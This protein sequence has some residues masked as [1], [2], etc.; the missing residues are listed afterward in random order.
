MLITT[1]DALQGYDIEK[2]LGLVFIVREFKASRPRKAIFEA[3]SALIS[4]AKARGANA[5]I[6]LRINTLPGDVNAIIAYGT[7]VKV[8]NLENSK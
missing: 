4:Q 1:T 6:G 5:L 3:L 7:A 8:K 2:T